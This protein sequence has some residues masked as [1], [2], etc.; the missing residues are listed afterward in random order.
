MDAPAFDLQSHSVH[1]DGALAPSAVVAA[2]A[3]AGVELL[4]LT[5]HDTVSGVPEAVASGV[6]HGV[7]VVAAVELSAVEGRHEDLHVLGYGFDHRDPELLTAL[8][9]YRGDRTRRGL[10]M[11]DALRELGFSLADS[12][13]ARQLTDGGSIGR[14]HLA[15][16]VTEHPDNRERLLTESLSD[17]TL[18]LQKY[19][20]PGQ[21]AY[22]GRSTPTIAEA[23]ATIHAAGGV[24]VW[25]H[26]FWDLEDPDE[27]QAAV[28]RFV[29]FG[30]D[31]VEVFYTTHDAEQTRF[32]SALCDEHELLSTGSADFHGPEHRMFSR[33]RAFSLHGCEPHLGPIAAV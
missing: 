25:A 16:A 33:F 28:E 4:A 2:A 23:I 5:D 21:A 1:S 19:L 9:H 26:P 17:P 22:R 11:A 14:P 10:A 30:L 3:A 32:L 24:A 18:V 13:L 15:R 7:G 6:Q 20:L 12:V 29:D 31:G 27:V 8:E